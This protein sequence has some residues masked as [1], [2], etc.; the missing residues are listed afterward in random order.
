MGA[1]FKKVRENIVSFLRMKKKRRST[2]PITVLQIIKMRDTETEIKRFSEFW[3]A[4]EPNHVIVKRFDTWA[5]QVKSIEEHAQVSYTSKRYG[6][7]GG[8]GTHVLLYGI[9]W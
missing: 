1:D 2:K 8:L 5:G 7:S 6:L 4:M 3:K 9:A